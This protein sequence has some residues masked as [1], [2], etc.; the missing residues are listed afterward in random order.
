MTYKMPGFVG[1]T[2]IPT[3]VEIEEY[4]QQHLASQ[5]LD[6]QKTLNST[7]KEFPKV[8]SFLDKASFSRWKFLYIIEQNLSNVFFDQSDIAHLDELELINAIRLLK[9]SNKNTHDL[10]LAQISRFYSLQTRRDISHTP[11]QAKQE[12]YQLIA[13]LL[14]R[15][16]THLRAMLFDFSLEQIQELGEADRL[17]LFQLAYE[18]VLR[19]GSIQEKNQFDLLKLHPHKDKEPV[20]RAISSA[21]NKYLPL[22]QR[23]LLLGS[24]KNHFAILFIPQ[25]EF[26]KIK[27]EGISEQT[28]DIE[29][30]LKKIGPQV[31]VKSE[32]TPL[33]QSSCATLRNFVCEVLSFATNAEYL[34]PMASYVP[35]LFSITLLQALYFHTASWAEHLPTRVS[36]QGASLFNSLISLLKNSMGEKEQERI[37]AEYEKIQ[38]RLQIGVQ[39]KHLFEIQRQAHEFQKIWG[40]ITEQAS[41][42]SYRTFLNA[43]YQKAIVPSCHY[44]PIPSSI[45]PD[46]KKR[47]ESPFESILSSLGRLVETNHPII[48]FILKRLIPR[49]LSFFI[50]EYPFCKIPGTYQI[51]P[52]RLH[53]FSALSNEEK[54]FLFSITQTTDPLLALKLFDHLPFFVLVK[55][56]PEAQN[57]EPNI[58]PFTSQEEGFEYILNLL[59]QEI[60]KE[61][62][63]LSLRKASFERKLL[64]LSQHAIPPVKKEIKHALTLQEELTRQIEST[65][66]MYEAFSHMEE[67][68]KSEELKK[69]LS[70][71][72]QK[73]EQNALLLKKSS[74]VIQNIGRKVSLLQ[75]KKDILEEALQALLLFSKNEEVPLMAEAQE[76][77]FFAT[78]VASIESGIKRMLID[79]SDDLSLFRQRS[80]YALL[81]RKELQRI[82]HE[83][84]ST[85]NRSTM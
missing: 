15:Q 20:F 9:R 72:E 11:H 45:T 43:L 42:P 18:K 13:R 46:N 41:D 38:K 49:L 22:E 58:T 2:K 35:S 77:L 36:F 1:N 51:P 74:E 3:H 71:L 69:N 25:E 80:K 19:H 67:R 57:I 4:F 60:E 50:H 21:I 62:K 55:H 23:A 5:L 48:P 75:A 82:T 28:I 8:L 52:E 65:Q 24:L 81:L 85:S 39:K 64:Y 30:L 70:I 63:R 68:Q 61:Q 16:S 33:F 6:L 29:L 54:K 78:L 79:A 66:S 31:F 83:H 12:L 14:A 76:Q 10:E 7:P 37:K 44:N 32:T 73:A 27:L 56:Y 40:Q 53:H 26:H 17:L 47:Y 84:Y 59:H 34:V